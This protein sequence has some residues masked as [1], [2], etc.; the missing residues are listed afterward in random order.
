M[1]VEKVRSAEGVEGVLCAEKVILV[2]GGYGF[3]GSNFIRY[4][5]DTH[6][7]K[8]VNVDICTYAA[9]ENNLNGYTTSPQ[10]VEYIND[11]CDADAISKIIK[12]ENVTDI[13]HFAAESHVDMSLKD[14]NLFVRTNVLG[15]SVL[16]EAFKSNNLTG[17]FHHVG[18]DEVY[19]DLPFDTSMF[20]EETPYN[21]SSPYSASKAASD[22]LVKSFNRSFNMNCTISN[23][24]NNYGPRQDNTKL[25][26]KVI[27]KTIKGEAIPVYGTGS[28][29]RD[30]LYVLDH[31]KAIDVIF[32]KAQPGSQYLIGGRNERTNLDIIHNIFDIMKSGDIEFVED[33]AGHDRRYAI[34]AAKLENELG[35][36]AEET[37]ET[38]I[39]KTI[40]WY[41]RR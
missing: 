29:V 20:T 13:I 25:I 24:S 23:C 4:M 7:Y 37:F 31:C 33:R 22:M 10:Y 16:L 30:W 12:R 34:N 26:P 41:K 1:D 38:G 19:G 8:I 32:H 40:K 21:P 35:W 28:N 18:T 15:T 39:V 11:I 14:P 2:T 17:R 36:K 6:N 27:E 3:I 5:I 9:N